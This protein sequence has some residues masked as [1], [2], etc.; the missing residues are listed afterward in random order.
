MF[1]IPLGHNIFIARANQLCGAY[2]F[3][4]KEVHLGQFWGCF[5]PSFL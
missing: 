2:S 1:F 4:G 5:D 3:V